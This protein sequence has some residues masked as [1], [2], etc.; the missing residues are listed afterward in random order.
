MKTVLTAFALI[1]ATSLSAH[2][3]D[4]QKYLSDTQ[5][6]VRQG[7][8]KEALERYQW[9]HDHAQ[10]DRIADVAGN[11]VTTWST[12]ANAFKGIGRVL[13]QFLHC[14]HQGG[15]VVRLAI[16]LRGECRTL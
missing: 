3:K 4:M 15:G 11:G 6:L 5:S 16:T 13:Q 14:I 10:V 12:Y 7:K 9:F 8:H 2:A 1:F